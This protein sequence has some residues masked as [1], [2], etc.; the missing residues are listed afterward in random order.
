MEKNCAFYKFVSR[1]L[2]KTITLALAAFILIPSTS[3]ARKKEK[4][5]G[6]GMANY[7][8]TEPDAMPK[9]ALGEKRLMHAAAVFMHNSNARINSKY[10]EGIDVSHYQGSINWDEVVNSTPIS[11]VYLKAT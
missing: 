3:F 10:K 6:R 11:Y 8:A 4:N 1:N 7:V 9:K 5:D 2:S